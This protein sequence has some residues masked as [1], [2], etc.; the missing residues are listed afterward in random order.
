MSTTFN[1]TAEEK[2]RILDKHKEEI[3]KQAEKKEVT[4]NGLRAPEK[5]EEKKD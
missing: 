5:K 4:K 3:K 1:M 2:Q